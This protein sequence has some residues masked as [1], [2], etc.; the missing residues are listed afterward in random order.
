[1]SSN[2]SFNSQ[3]F[4]GEEIAFESI[5]K[6]LYEQNNS[7]NDVRE[8]KRL[9]ILEKFKSEP[10]DSLVTKTEDKVIV[11]SLI[12]YPQLTYLLL[13]LFLRA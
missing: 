2:L 13:L 11:P 10:F 3:K 9:Q 8:E 1:M 4:P 5:R 7:D 6:L 12:H